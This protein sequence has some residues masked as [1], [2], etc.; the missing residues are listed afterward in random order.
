[1]GFKAFTDEE[2]SGSGE[3]HKGFLPFDFTEKQGA[4][5]Q[6]WLEKKK[7]D[8]EDEKKRQEIE[9]IRLEEKKKAEEK[10]G[11]GGAL[12]H[13]V[14]DLPENLKRDYGGVLAPIGEVIEKGAKMWSK[15]KTE[16][17]LAFDPSFREETGS[18]TGKA[19]KIPLLEEF[20]NKDTKEERKVEIR[21]QVTERAMANDPILMGLNTE[22]GKKTAGWIGD[23]S[24]NLGLKMA[25]RNKAIYTFGIKNYEDNLN[26]LLEK[27]NDPNNNLYEKVMYG[28]QD[29]GL[30]SGIGV[31]LALVPY[32]GTSLSTAFYT[33]ISADEQIQENGRVESSA[34]I[35]V[36]VVGDRILSGVADDA[37]KNF[38]TKNGKKLLTDLIKGGTTEGGTEVTQSVIKMSEEYANATSD[39]ERKAAADKLANY[40]KEG[41]IT[42]EFL[43]A[44]GAG[45]M[46]TSVAG[47][48]N[49]AG[50]DPNLVVDEQETP[51]EKTPEQIKEDS[52]TKQK[53]VGIPEKDMV[54]PTDEEIAEWQESK[55][56]DKQED[57]K[58]RAIE[59][60]E[61]LG[62]REDVKA[63]EEA[64]EISKDIVEEKYRP[65]YTAKESGLQA[66]LKDAMARERELRADDMSETSPALR[67]TLKQMK[68]LQEK[69]Y[70]EQQK[71]K[72][73]YRAEPTTPAFKNWFGESKVVGEDGSPQVMYHG[74]S[75][76]IEAFSSAFSGE[77]TGN[78]EAEGFYFTNKET[79]AESYSKEAFIR[80]NEEDADRYDKADEQVKTTPVYLKMENPLIVE[81]FDGRK[82]DTVKSQQYV[83]FAKGEGGE[84]ADEI[85][86]EMLEDDPAEFYKTVTD[87]DESMIADNK[88]EIIEHI[89]NEVGI[90]KSEITD[91]DI[92][93]YAPEYLDQNGS[94]ENRDFDGVIFKN[95]IDNI[96]VG[97]EEEQDV[98]VVFDPSQIKSV[99]NKG[100]FSPHDDRIKY[101]SGEDALLERLKKINNTMFPDSNIKLE[102]KILSPEGHNQ[103]GS[104]RAGMI[105]ILKGQVEPTD[106][107]YHESVHKFL[108]FFATQEEYE[109]VF[110]E[111]QLKYDTQ[112]RTELEE[113]IAEDF[114]KFANAKNESGIIGKAIGR[115]KRYFKNE[116]A[117]KQ[118]Y[119]DIYG[120][121]A[122][123][124]DKE[125]KLAEKQIASE[126]QFSDEKQGQYGRFKGLVRIDLL[127]K[128]ED[129]QQFYEKYPGNNDVLYSQEQTDDEVFQEFKEKRFNDK[130]MQ[131]SMKEDRAEIRETKKVVKKEK[132]KERQ[133]RIVASK[134]KAETKSVQEEV[135]KAV[136][137][138]TPN[139]KSKFLKFLKNTQTDKQL[140][141]TYGK[142]MER[143]EKLDVAQQ[144]RELKAEI[145]K[146]LSN[147]KTISQTGKPKG[148]FT[149]FTQQVMDNAR[150]ALGLS[151]AKAQ[152]KIMANLFAYPDGQMPEEKALENRMLEMY[153]GMEEMNPSKLSAVL[154]DIVETKATGRA[155]NELQKFNLQADRD[156]LKDFAVD[157]ITDGK[158]IDTSATAFGKKKTTMAQ[159]FQTLGRKMVFSWDGLVNIV[160]SKTSVFGRKLVE[161]LSV[162]RQENTFKEYQ[163]EMVADV[164]DAVSVAYGVKQG[165]QFKIA[166]KIADLQKEINLGT[167]K[168]LDGVEGELIMTKDQII[169]RWMEMR[170]TSIIASLVD[171]NRM[172]MPM[173]K[174][175]N[176]AMT[177]QDKVFARMQ[178]D[179]YEKQYHRINAKYSKINGVDLPHNANYSPI[180]REGYQID[181]SKGF[182]EFIEDATHRTA[183]SSGSLKSRVKSNLPLKLQGSLEVLTRHMSETNY[184]SAWVEKVR[185][186]DSL[187][188]NTEVRTAIKQELGDKFLGSI[189][190][191][192]NDMSTNGNKT[193]RNNKLIDLLRTKFTLG[194]LMIKPALAAKQ[195]VSTLAY[196][197]KVGPVDFAAGVADFWLNPIKNARILNKESTLIRT[198]GANMDRDINDVVQSSG[199]KLSQS[200]SLSNA[201]MLNIKLGDKGA[202]L[203]GSWALRRAR[204]KQGVELGDIINE[205]ENFSANTQQSAD[206]SRLSE[207][208]RGSS[209]EKLFTMFM[210]SQRGY[211]AK[212]VAAI[213]S[214][215]Q[216]DGTKSANVKKVANIIAI[217]HFILPMVFQYIANLGG[218]DDEDKK[219][220]KRAA[221]LGSFNGL[222]IVGDIA[223][224]VIRQA[225]GL[226]VW[227]NEI[228]ITGLF[229]DVQKAIKTLDV[230]DITGEDIQ[231]AIG[232]VSEF[233]NKFG[234]PVKQVKGVY[235]GI[236]DI[237]EG[238]YKQGAAKI[239][240]WSDYRAEQRFKNDSEMEKEYKKYKEENDSEKD[241]MNDLI[242]RVKEDG[243]TQAE[244]EEIQKLLDDKKL[245]KQTL[246]TKLQR[247]KTDEEKTL[248][249]F[250]V[251]DGSRAKEI[252]RQLTGKS[253]EEKKKMMREF[254]EV[255]LLSDT[256]I[257]QLNTL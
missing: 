103:L 5:K 236:V 143:I 45:G 102:D 155:I 204:L 254:D 73:K 78:N 200:G 79:T 137:R 250:Q 144:K 146:E 252:K 82:L 107:L 97:L 20:K 153:S 124:R 31:G 142:M 118:L 90:E 145:K 235:G 125:A 27:R 93:T 134:T 117:I 62:I 131:E 25:A 42:E 95:T 245:T 28:I 16:H 189:E 39:K 192:I 241:A 151:K 67:R 126:N 84:L 216:K 94:L 157:R 68:G 106:T 176:N 147:T 87:Y 207:V 30:Q 66:D 215:F 75:E 127:D 65:F 76:N 55:Q 251:G 36:D 1:M 173:L 7:K 61:E 43:T 80:K 203:T 49:Q 206:T 158:G 53:E 232:E 222:F 22:A 230:E 63:T 81:A 54:V 218:W 193:A 101:R 91:E 17:H 132:A 2:M 129:A 196:L 223:D 11:I 100:A 44:F 180:A 122:I 23:K 175:I 221:W 115:I 69:I 211:L 46:I 185:E 109:Q 205:Y 4:K 99:D 89:E 201:L 133:P 71:A 186:L 166:G 41:K 9:K 120:G 182:G 179:V 187:F 237:A 119:E 168:N 60:Q 121:E 138:L 195:M 194:A 29:S 92:K 202:I 15:A 3:Y 171:G 226:R 242:D 70:I 217:Y 199:G 51:E 72:T 246:K 123:V 255:G 128:L 47:G 18:K 212:E 208:Q 229:D 21:E 34:G 19:Y 56:I 181:T 248:G 113:L 219:E 64:R 161:K 160:E 174:A 136:D 165:S 177:E 77:T 184:Y 239:L 152:D 243:G 210:S 130:L 163:E 231:E 38:G 197:E 59:I 249:K 224:G 74:S 96:E 48:F 256:V 116:K 178:F 141:A 253:L 14:L 40:I 57:T 233:G 98:H 225:L 247:D 52:M 114:I 227:D 167:F 257:K 244:K 191:A 162:L 32:A 112:D 110:T 140:V 37:L 220:Y 240:G 86:M 150:S 8:D 228:P 33:A 169:K 108:E 104:H 156:A 183:L 170:D 209:L 50:V 85:L 214:V 139:D 105:K 58:K 149:P 234:V 135:I 172:S 13:A 159:A 12:K 88:D 190:N 10:Q 164:S 35:F 111:A 154:S 238:D 213:Q 148:K 188:K 83:Q 198:R 26:E 6:A 24:S